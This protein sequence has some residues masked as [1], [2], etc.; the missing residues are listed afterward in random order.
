MM[1]DLT[2]LT[3]LSQSPLE[4]PLR[5]ERSLDQSLRE[6]QY[7]GKGAPQDYYRTAS[8]FTPVSAGKVSLESLRQSQCID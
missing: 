3:D 7:K 6:K 4:D 5:C 2:L 1:P 8:W